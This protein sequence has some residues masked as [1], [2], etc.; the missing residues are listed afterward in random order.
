MEVSP[1]AEDV[2]TVLDVLQFWDIARREYSWEMFVAQLAS[3]AFGPVPNIKSV[4][5]HIPFWVV[6]F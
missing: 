3:L 4:S 5:C 2:A 6:G 1:D